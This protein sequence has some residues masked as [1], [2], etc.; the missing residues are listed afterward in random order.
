MG[1]TC[2]SSEG[3]ENSI[4]AV[5][6]RIQERATEVASERAAVELAKAELAQLQNILQQEEKKTGAVRRTM[7]STVRER[8]GVEMELYKVCDL[9]EERLSKLDDYQRETNDAKEEMMQVHE[10]WEDTVDDLYVEHNLQRELYKRCVNGRIKRREECIKERDQKLRQLEQETKSFEE[11]TKHMTEETRQLEENIVD[12]DS[13][14]EKEDEEVTALS[15]QIRA[16]IQKVSGEIWYHVWCVMGWL[17]VPY[18]MPVSHVST[19]LFGQRTSLRR[20]LRDAEEAC[21]NANR[22]MKEWEQKR[23][24]IVNRY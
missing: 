14:E 4:A 12:M 3:G 5:A 17:C 20:T 18:C 11:E 15:M 16:T 21:Q 13:R 9:Q 23:L 10:D 22:E 1:D 24:D 7:L 2:T 6:A 8:H 19:V